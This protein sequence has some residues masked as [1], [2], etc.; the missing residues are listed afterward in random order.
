MAVANLYVSQCPYCGHGLKAHAD[1]SR[2]A[3]SPN[4]P[5]PEAPIQNGAIL[6]VVVPSTVKVKSAS[7]PAAQIA[8][9]STAETSGWL[10]F[11]VVAA[12][13][14]LGL[15]WVSGLPFL[16]LASLLGG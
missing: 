12:V 7:I 5:K 2:P 13:F 11:A 1:A 16:L 4:L 15:S 14:A 9:P 8:K 6:A 3:R 10:S